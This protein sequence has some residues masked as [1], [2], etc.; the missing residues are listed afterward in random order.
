MPLPP[1]HPGLDPAHPVLLFDG[2]CGLCSRSVAS[3]LRLD[4]HGVFRFAPLQSAAAERLLLAADAP[5]PLPE[6]MIVVD[7]GR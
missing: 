5:H 6:S 2:V 1:D 4:R 7:G 3:V